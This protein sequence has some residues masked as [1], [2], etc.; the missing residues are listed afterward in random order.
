[1]LYYLQLDQQLI[2]PFAGFG[3][4][5]HELPIENCGCDFLDASAPHLLN[6]DSGERVEVLAVGPL[7]AGQVKLAGGR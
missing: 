5:K 6:K 3:Q 2:H 7:W 4:V 1:M